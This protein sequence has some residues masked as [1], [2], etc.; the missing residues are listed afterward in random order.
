VPKRAV[1]IKQLKPNRRGS[2]KVGYKN[3]TFG[4][5][6]LDRSPYGQDLRQGRMFLLVTTE[7]LVFTRLKTGCQFQSSSL[8]AINANPNAYLETVETIRLHQ[9]GSLSCND[10]AILKKGKIVRATKNSDPSV[11]ITLKRHSPAFGQI[12]G[13]MNYQATQVR[14]TFV[15]GKLVL[16]A[17]VDTRRRYGQALKE[18]RILVRANVCQGQEKAK[19]YLKEKNP[20]DPAKPKLKLIATV[21]GVDIEKSSTVKL[22]DILEEFAAYV[23]HFSSDSEARGI[24]WK[25]L[26]TRFDRASKKHLWDGTGFDVEL[27]LSKRTW[28]VV[29]EVKGKK[30]TLYT[31]NFDKDG[32]F[33]QADGQ[34]YQKDGQEVSFLEKRSEDEFIN[35]WD[36]VASG[37]STALTSSLEQAI[38]AAQKLQKVS[39]EIAISTARTKFMTNKLDI[40]FKNAHKKALLEGQG[41][42]ATLTRKSLKL[43]KIT[44]DPKQAAVY[45]VKLDKDGFFLLPDG[46]RYLKNGQ[47]VSPFVLRAKRLYVN[48]WDMVYPH[49]IKPGLPAPEFLEAAPFTVHE[50]AT[51]LEVVL[52]APYQPQALL[53]EAEFSKEGILSF[54]TPK[55]TLAIYCQA[56]LNQSVGQTALLHFEYNGK[57]DPVLRVYD[58]QKKDQPLATFFFDRELQLFYFYHRYAKAGEIEERYYIVNFMDGP[59]VDF[60]NVFFH[61]ATRM[62]GDI[63]LVITENGKWTGCKNKDFN[64][65]ANASMLDEEA[66]LIGVAVGAN[67]PNPKHLAQATGYV[68]TKSGSWVYVEQGFVTRE[69]AGDGTSFKDPAYYQV[70]RN[71]DWSVHMS[72][73][74]KTRG[75]DRTDLKIFERLWTHFFVRD[76]DNATP[77]EFYTILD[78]QEVTARFD[79]ATFDP[80]T[81][82]SRPVSAVRVDNRVE[83]F[84]VFEPYFD[85]L[86]RQI[87][88]LMMQAHNR[89][90]YNPYLRA[91][92]DTAYE[93]YKAKPG[94]EGL[95]AAML[96]IGVIKSILESK[97]RTALSAPQ[98]VKKVPAKPVANAAQPKK[99]RPPKPRKPKLAAR[100]VTKKKAKRKRLS[101]AEKRQRLADGLIAAADSLNGGQAVAKKAADIIIASA[102]LNGHVKLV[103][104]FVLKAMRAEEDP[105]AISQSIDFLHFIICN[106][107]PAKFKTP[108]LNLYFE[109]QKRKAKYRHRM[110]QL[111]EATVP[112]QPAVIDFYAQLLKLAAGKEKAALL[113]KTLIGILYLDRNFPGF[114]ADMLPQAQSA[115]DFLQ[116]GKIEGFLTKRNYIDPRS[117]TF[118]AR[119]DR[120][121][122]E[123]K[124]LKTESLSRSLALGF[125]NQI[126]RL[127]DHHAELTVPLHKKLGSDYLAA[128]TLSREAARILFEEWGYDKSSP[129]L[130]S[131][132]RARLA[133]M[134]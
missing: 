57:A 134:K 95:A 18:G 107:C 25:A 102:S 90:Q 94:A 48:F 76:C 104:G 31:V 60:K 3:L 20:K 61:K 15:F 30:I 37:Y 122:K 119:L 19:L 64:S 127:L 4:L 17:S 43:E 88:D 106:G 99:V 121:R 70:V 92:A 74:E 56:L 89:G 131:S 115:F 120:A 10:K 13:S 86:T 53:V 29:K 9:D 80:D 128:Y 126:F 41:C 52:Q 47:P 33:L 16:R 97:P 117:S 108:A 6:D 55:K 110:I 26:T 36:I 39:L 22:E 42:K 83:L 73:K 34:R 125:A 1:A 124:E 5:G 51:C 54:E 21:E 44:D 113:T 84:R 77:T 112:Q 132:L 35:F 7:A 8:A 109:A 96:Q 67:R 59:R 11:H 62:L 49:N 98:P 12:E 116:A 100:K 133:S 38:V 40:G 27:C 118:V 81:F 123:F 129:G 93:L 71:P 23:W 69:V 103:Q 32:Y 45:E 85:P 111:I 75:A 28:K 91:A 2:I 24:K 68:G 130:H 72:G 14:A 66:K 79:R 65:I 82:V 63:L 58:P 101:A 50:L 114:Y 87:A 78:R 46:K 105:E